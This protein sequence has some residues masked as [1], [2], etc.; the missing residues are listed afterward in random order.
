[1][2][3]PE[4]KQK[5]LKEKFVIAVDI[6]EEMGKKDAEGSPTQMDKVRAAVRSLCINKKK[7]FPSTS[8]SLAVVTDMVFP[9]ARVKRLFFILSASKPFAADDVY[10]FVNDQIASLAADEIFH[11]VLIYGRDTTPPISCTDVSAMHSVISH[12]RVFIDVMFLHEKVTPQ[13]NAQAIYDAL[14]ELHPSRGIERMQQLEAASL[15]TSN[16]G[17]SGS[18]SEGTTG[19][20][21][22]GDRLRLR[23]PAKNSFVFETSKKAYRSFAVLF[24]RFL[25]H[26]LQRQPQDLHF[27]KVGQS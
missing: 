17:E 16:T 23:V 13:S 1:M 19:A 7:L 24:S 15:R 9:R 2:A 22:P 12:P 14:M 18:D 8:F 5:L 21:Q 4:H 26:P 25:C 11:L 10:A 20:G 3:L 27:A 6:G